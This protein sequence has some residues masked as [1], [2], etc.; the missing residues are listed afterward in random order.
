MTVKYKTDFYASYMLIDIPE[1]TD[2]NQYSFKMLERNHIQGILPVKERKEDGKGCLYVDISGKKSLAQ[3]YKDKEM[4]L[5]EMV[6]FFQQLMPVLEEL[7]KYLLTEKMAVL[8]PE[9]IYRDMEDNQLYITVLPWEVEE[10]NNLHKLAEFFLEKINHKD[11]F[12]VNAA[13]HFY[14]QQSQPH[15]SL[16]Y[17]IP[18]LEK[19]NIL[20]RQQKKE[21]TE[22]KQWDNLVEIRRGE[23]LSE[24]RN[25]VMWE[26]P[27]ENLETE[28]KQI[29]RNKDIGIWMIVI[30]LGIISISFLPIL[31]FKQKLSGM[32]L[33]V[34]FLVTGI[35]I[36]LFQ[37]LQSKKKQEETEKEEFCYKEVV[38]SEPGMEDTI[39]FESDTS[40]ELLKLQ[41]KEKGRAKQVVLREFPCT[42]GKVKEEV[43]IVMD[44]P[45]VSRVHCR[46]VEK[47]RGIAIMDLNSTNGT[48]L[49][50]IQL[51][52]GEILEIVKNDE[53]LI[54]KVK[55]LVV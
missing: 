20:K 46:F 29:R 8:E 38:E 55:V 14:K 24:D 33:A 17:F 13:Y 42:L 54:G 34:M 50:G 7:R 31:K 41:W 26:Q 2:R 25:E 5:E 28:K 22:V 3:E 18:V 40:E 1:E 15:F 52:E 4:E 12:G 6:F 10:G 53:I 16:Y 43:S 47:D 48:Y 36:K 45:S 27:C 44:N 51:K 19:E 32:A 9:Y 49:N 30:G 37:Y 11:E 21:K 35:G 39:F 23:S